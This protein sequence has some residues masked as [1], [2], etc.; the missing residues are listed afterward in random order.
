MNTFSR[1]G[2]RLA[3]LTAVLLALAGGVAY[4]TI[5]DSG[6]VYTACMLDGAGTIRLIDPSLPST[7]VISHCTPKETQIAWNAKG[8]PGPPG[9]DGADGKDG[10]S[11]TSTAL[12]SGDANC[13]NGGSKFVAANGVT[14]ACD[15]AD[16]T[17][18]SP[19]LAVSVT[20]PQDELYREVL[21]IPGVAK[22]FARC[23]AAVR[24][25]NIG[26][27]PV[28]GWTR[29]APYSGAY[30]QFNLGPGAIAAFTMTYPSVEI[31]LWSVGAPTYAAAMT[32]FIADVVDT[33][34]CRVDIHA[35]TSS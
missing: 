7:N 29:N 28:N 4:A 11:V 16:G 9:K 20:F 19:L 18:G 15:G 33:Q 13:P 30:A 35:Q 1:R 21:T 17:N 14:Y 23:G 10:V 32:V 5:P 8:D 12:A 26:T 22:V 2:V 27:A 34:T 24:V 6:G 25:Q 3:G 31:D